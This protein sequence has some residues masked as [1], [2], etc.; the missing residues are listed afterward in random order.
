[1]R[2]LLFIICLFIFTTYCESDKRNV[3]TMYGTEGLVYDFGSDIEGAI[4]RTARIMIDKIYT[5]M[6]VDN[7]PFTG[8]NE[9]LSN[10]LSFKL[11][12]KILMFCNQ[13]YDC[14]IKIKAPECDGTFDTDNNIISF[15]HKLVTVATINKHGKK[16]YDSKIRHILCIK[17]KK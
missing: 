17:N 16:I 6:A 7:D 9:T 5:K 1:M 14:E 12:Q 3:V 10:D 13:L 11:F 2:A 8:H 4:L 15:E